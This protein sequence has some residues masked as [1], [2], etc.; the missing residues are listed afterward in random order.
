M[1]LGVIF[2][3]LG[4]IFYNIYA[5]TSNGRA[6]WIWTLIVLGLTFTL[7][8]SLLSIILL[9]KSESTKIS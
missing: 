8:F 3:F 7:V 1:T 2:L 9:T 4:V 6:W 5:N